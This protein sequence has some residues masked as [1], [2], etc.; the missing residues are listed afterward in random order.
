MYVPTYIHIICT[1]VCTHNVSNWLAL[2]KLRHSTHLRNKRHTSNEWCKKVLP[3]RNWTQYYVYTYI[4][5]YMHTYVY[6]DSRKS[7]LLLIFA[8]KHIYVC[9]Y[10]K[11]QIHTYRYLYVGTT[12]FI[13]KLFY[14]YIM[15]VFLS[16][17][18]LYLYTG[19]T[20]L[21]ICMYICNM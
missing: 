3:G 16:R 5:T 17:L 11:L 15:F 14:T 8:Y 19:I 2:I 7:K 10:I 18:F 6:L 12:L 1:Y 9:K 4:G 21:H 20:Y 13:V